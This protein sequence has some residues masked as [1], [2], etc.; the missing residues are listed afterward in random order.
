MK[1]CSVG[2]FLI[3]K[4]PVRRNRLVWSAWQ[5]GQLRWSSPEFFIVVLANCYVSMLRQRALYRM[6]CCGSS[7]GD[8]RQAN[9]AR[10]ASVGSWNLLEFATGINEGPC[11]LLE[12][13]GAS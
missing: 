6:S 2:P 7:G 11:H 13:Q 1:P 12:D 5:N 8:A 10:N 9:S 3:S 4:N